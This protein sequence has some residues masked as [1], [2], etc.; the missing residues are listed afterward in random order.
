MKKSGAKDFNIDIKK[1]KS[2]NNIKK[3]FLEWKFIF[4][5]KDEI[6]RF[7]QVNF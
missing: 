1:R 7:K 4:L 2:Q 3:K 6:N 5:L